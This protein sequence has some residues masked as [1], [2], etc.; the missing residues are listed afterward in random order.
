MFLESVF[1]GIESHDHLLGGKTHMRPIFKL[2]LFILALFLAIAPAM[3]MAQSAGTAGSSTTTTTTG[4]AAAGGSSSTM[5][6][7]NNS[8][9]STNG[10]AT[11]T[12]TS[13]TTTVPWVWIVVGAVVVVGIIA[14]VAT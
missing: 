11:T 9:S 12:T 7:P 2:S 6:T 5:T 1:L 3:T 8:T 4:P 14:I 10:A 13:T